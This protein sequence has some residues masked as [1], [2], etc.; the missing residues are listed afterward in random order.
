VKFLKTVIQD[1][2][3]I[4]K[5]TGT[6]NKKLLVATSILFSQLSVITDVFLIGLFAFLIGDQKTNIEFVDSLASYFDQNR[7]LILILIILRFVFMYYQSLILR[8]IEYRVSKNMKEYILREIFE[9]RNF[10]V[11]DSYFFTNELSLHIGF[12]YSKVAAFI[13][14]TFQLIVYCAYL[15]SSNA[16]VLGIF[17][18]GLLFLFYPIKKIILISRN[19]VDKTYHMGRESMSEIERVVENLF[20][21]KI[22]K[23]EE[24]ELQKFSDTLKLL[25][26]TLL[27]NHKFGVLNGFLPSFLTLFILGILI[28]FFSSAV[29]L[30][31][32]FIGVTLKLFGSVSGL[33]GS[34]SNII[35]SHVH[36][37]KFKELEFNKVD[38][39]KFNFLIKNQNSIKF[40]NTGFKYQ[41]NDEKIF[42]G[43]NLEIPKGK[44][45]LLTG[46]N[47][48]GKS[49]MLG[50]VAGVFY[51]TEGKVISFSNRYGYVSAYPFI[52]RDTLFNNLVYGIEDLNISKETLTNNLKLFNT[53][54]EESNYDLS[55]IISNKSLSSGQMQ[56]IAFIRSLLS[57][58]DIM[59]LDE[60]TSNLDV[61]TKKLIFDLLQKQNVTIL[62]ST[63][64]AENFGFSD[65][66]IEISIVNEKRVVKNLS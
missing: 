5:L 31:L 29:T 54:K 58:P 39:F 32:D 17:G 62:N 33:T 53:F 25:N 18:I 23:K 57:N 59:L 2:L 46:E 26:K 15:I 55:R 28:V 51:P 65:H 12:F 30:T 36:M 6:Q 60:S 41:N 61:E 20:L 10:S 52:F 56:K 16:E 34:F 47:G 14:N 19:Y 43:L 1:I 27:N 66:H 45:T 40:E 8:K 48:S 38:K 4:S 35:N 21:I 64:D 63:H 11:S 9:K 42:S 49:T 24:S 44:H 37:V 3:L 50:L 7:Y 13:N 22:M